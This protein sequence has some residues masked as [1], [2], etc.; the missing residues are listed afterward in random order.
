LKKLISEEMY[1][2]ALDSISVPFGES[3]FC[4]KVSGDASMDK[5]RT[6][7]IEL[8]NEK[9][10]LKKQEIY[11]GVE[12]KLKEKIPVNVY[13]KITSELAIYSGK[14]WKRKTGSL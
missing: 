14:E 8:F 4:R 5:Y 2:S 9:S 6:I 1:Q 12:K 11:D 10:I 7:I 3:A 13:S